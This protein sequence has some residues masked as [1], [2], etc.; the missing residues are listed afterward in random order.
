MKKLRGPLFD[1]NRVPAPPQYAERYQLRPDE[2]MG[3]DYNGFFIYWSSYNENQRTELHVV[4]GCGN[5]WDH[6]SVSTRARC[7]VWHEM[8]QI[9]RLFFEEHETAFQLHVAVKNHISIHPYT[10]HL[11]RPHDHPIP[12]PPHYMV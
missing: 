11:W 3:N 1:H 6:V 9:K 8:E 10:L 12:L 7:P 2:L 4:A 5:G